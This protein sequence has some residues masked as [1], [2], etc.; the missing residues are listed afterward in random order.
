VK[1]SDGLTNT[2]GL[3]LKLRK[4]L[5]IVRTV[6]TA[7]DDENRAIAEGAG[8]ISAGAVNSAVNSPW[9]RNNSDPQQHRLLERVVEFGNMK[10]AW[11][12]VK[13]NKGSYGIDGRTIADTELFLKANWLALRQTIRDETFKPYPVKRVEIPKPGGGIRKLG[14]PTVVDRVIQQAIC[15]VLNPI[16]DPS[17]SEFSYGFRPNKSA[18]DAV[19]QA[20][21][22]QEDGKQ[23]VVDMDLKQFFDEVNHDILISRLG[24][25]VKDKRLKRLINAYLKSGVMTISDGYLP[26]EKG[27]P[28]GGP[29]SPLLSNILLDDLDKELEKRG[30]NFCRYADDCNIYVGSRKA[31]ERVMQ[32]VTE[33]VE[34]LLKLKVNKEKS[35]VDRPWKRKFLGFSSQKVFGKIRTSVPEEIIK[36]F[37]G[38]M[39]KLF[40]EGRGRNVAR[41][42]IERINPV[43]RGWLQ[44]FYLGLSLKQ[45]QTF[46]FWIRRRFR[47]LIWRQWKRPSTRI[48]KLLS[49]GI[50]QGKACYANN[51]KGPWWNAGIPVVKQALS[52]EYFKRLELYSMTDNLKRL[53]ITL[54]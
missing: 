14:I 26:S 5:F 32:T 1:D 37:R 43:L 28:Q 16:F 40:H 45:M 30:H 17:F 42:I 4:E 7:D 35:A 12:Q 51:R 46:D 23:W 44:Y 2:E 50:T 8:R 33:Y 41:F 53:R 52:P 24:R 9:V 21:K 39:K 11:K 15:Q 36:R 47:C 25:K 18:H 22:H 20:R 38:R 34:K 27:T 13:K 31:G 48:R 6:Y 29:L 49:L 10:L 54:T 3:N 19:R